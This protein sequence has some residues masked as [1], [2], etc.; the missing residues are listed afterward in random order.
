MY[1]MK[2]PPIRL[3]AI[4]V[5][6]LS[7]T[8][9]SRLFLIISETT[10]IGRSIGEVI[11][12]I[13]METYDFPDYDEIKTKYYK[14]LIASRHEFLQM[15]YDSYKCFDFDKLEKSKLNTFGNSRL[16]GLSLLFKDDSE[17]KRYKK[18]LEEFL[19]GF[20]TNKWKEEIYNINEKLE[21]Q[22][23]A[24]SGIKKTITSRNNLDIKQFEFL[25][26]D[27]IP[28]RPVNKSS[29]KN[30]GSKLTNDVKIED[31]SMFIFKSN[32][33]KIISFSGAAAV[34]LDKLKN[35]VSGVYLYQENKK[36]I[37]LIDP[38][39]N[40]KII[41]L[42]QISYKVNNENFNLSDVVDYSSLEKRAEL[43]AGSRFRFIE[44]VAIVV[45]KFV[46]AVKKIWKKKKESEKILHM[47]ENNQ[48]NQTVIKAKDGSKR[49]FESNDAILQS[50]SKAFKESDKFKLIKEYITC[51]EI[52]ELLETL[53]FSNSKLTKEEGV[54][55]FKSLLANKLKEKESSKQQKL[56]Q[57][58]EKVKNIVVSNINVKSGLKESQ[59]RYVKQ[60]RP[61]INEKSDDDLYIEEDRK[62]LSVINP[63]PSH[64]DNRRASIVEPY[65]IFIEPKRRFEPKKVVDINTMKA[66]IKEE[67]KKN[68]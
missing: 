67:M 15:I 55:K 17:S 33:K 8:S 47:Q 19:L 41:F 38:S 59:Y 32:A 35:T 9:S 12:I 10:V 48:V 34:N 2:T 54:K 58:K 20:E 4:L 22:I 50:N 62:V 25:S 7:K 16:E 24:K 31:N 40:N 6:L 45:C 61:S 27:K 36:K 42:D 49:F 37:K 26:F 64:R 3:N 65:E 63:T 44:K 5:F 60:E 51:R 14:D 13:I 52:S 66:F 21:N 30:K 1:K 46:I 11:Y 56:F 53:K 18:N 29:F 23:E 43:L 28:K 68:K 39:K 57:I